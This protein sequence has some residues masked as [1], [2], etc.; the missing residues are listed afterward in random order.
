MIIDTQTGPFCIGILSGELVCKF[1]SSLEVMP[2]PERWVKLL[3]RYF[4]GE[5][6]DFSHAPLPK[7]SPFVQKCWIACR[8]IPHGETITYGELAQAAGSPRAARAAGQAMRRNPMPVMTPCH[9]VIAASGKLHGF[10]GNT[11]PNSKELRTKRFLLA[12]EQPHFER[13]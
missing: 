9:R 6:I 2:P 4:A 10:A 11:F 13:V 1:S 12:L 3:R 8:E 7:G 5:K